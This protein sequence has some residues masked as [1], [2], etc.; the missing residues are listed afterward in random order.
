[1][2]SF[3]FFR[4]LA[5]QGDGDD[6]KY[7]I[8]KFHLPSKKMKRPPVPSCCIKNFSAQVKNKNG[9]LRGCGGVD[10]KKT[11]VEKAVDGAD[12]GARERRE[13]HVEENFL[14]QMRAN[15]LPICEN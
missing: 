11:N 2:F 13:I 6:G 14:A 10:T 7:A 3:F 9:Y 15:A 8:K 5:F 12:V 4:F 1:M